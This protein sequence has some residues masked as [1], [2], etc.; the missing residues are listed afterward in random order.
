MDRRGRPCL[1][2]RVAAWWRL[3]FVENT[4]SAPTSSFELSPSLPHALL[5]HTVCDTVSR[6]PTWSKLAVHLV[7]AAT[8]GRN[9]GASQSVANP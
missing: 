3:D 8:K 4:I 6:P 5:L 1:I 7:S 9:T 2:A